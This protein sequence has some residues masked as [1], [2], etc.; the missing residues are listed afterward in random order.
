MFIKE[1][2]L[3]NKKSGK[4]YHFH[5]LIQSVRTPRGPRHETVTDLGRLEIP[6][7]Q[8]KT[9]ANRIE[10]IL[11]GQMAITL[12][13]VTV[14]QLAQ[15]YARRIRRKERQSLSAPPTAEEARKEAPEWE[16]VDLGSIAQEEARSV[17][18]EVIGH[19]AFQQLGLPAIFAELGFA[20]KHIDLV[21]L[22][23]V[24]RLLHPASERE[25]AVF[26]RELSALD[27]VLGTDFSELADSALYRV[28]DRITAQREFIE[29]RLTQR[30]RQVFGLGE[31]I[32]LYD[33]TNTYL[34]G[35]GTASSL[36]ARGRCKQKRS[37]CPLLTLALVLDE[38]GFP[39]TSKIF[40]GNASEPQTL[41]SILESLPKH[42]GQMQLFGTPP[43]V[44]I[45]AGIATQE[46]LAIIREYKMQYICV[47]RIRPTEAPVG[48]PVIIKDNGVDSV[49]GIRYE[50]N[51]EVF[52]HCMST[53]RA[54]KESS[55]R[56]RF[57][58]R[59]ENALDRLA[60]SIA[61][62]RGVKQSE[63]VHKRLGR[64]LERFPLVSNWYKIKVEEVEDRV[65][66]ISWSIK[67]GQAFDMRFSGAYLIRSSRTD[68]DE[69]DLWTTY[70]MLT[71]VEAAFRAL[72]SELGL[73]PVYH[74]VDRRL[75]GHL[76]IAVLAYHLLAIIQ[77]TLR[78][79]GICFSWETIRTRM[80]SQQRIT[81][82]MTNNREKR[83][84]IRQ[85]TTAEPFHQEIYL[86]LG[87][88][89]RP[90]KSI[91]TVF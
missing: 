84:S 39:K 28:A 53:G 49:R 80:A 72:K 65:Q 7:E 88:S 68:L 19:W 16:T 42:T 1:I 62:P 54:K 75:E 73:R 12:P 58:Q 38:D 78:R 74:Q 37:D 9:L 18:G 8:W 21:E 10:E 44:V 60:S 13:P 40:A 30:E 87:I 55:I 51:G 26:A 56:G 34:E 47:S 48:E 52:L 82:S 43:T 17:G 59:F 90:V 29:Q 46:N 85:T 57:Q 64:I 63:K 20:A 36:A 3:R 71:T 70:T 91:R 6:K 89:S 24:S 27:E 32:I 33:L 15:Q 50:R 25:T 67:D 23:I 31:K 66:S 69:K 83:I 45:D 79:K 76:F 81:V 5:R 35:T 2:T 41:R 14:E 22:L 61:R 86:A 11:C 77:R 4:P